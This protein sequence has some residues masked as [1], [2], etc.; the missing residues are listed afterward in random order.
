LGYNFEKCSK[1]KSQADEADLLSLENISV[2]PPKDGERMEIVLYWENSVFGLF[3]ST[4]S[5]PSCP[6][7]LDVLEAAVPLP[8]PPL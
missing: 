6:L 1:Y 2:D 3:Y 8:S 7:P 5:Q 4:L